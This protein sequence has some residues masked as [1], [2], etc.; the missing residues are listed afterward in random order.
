MLVEHARELAGV[1]DAAHAE[2]GHGGTPVISLLSCSLV[3]TEIDIDIVPGTRLA[4][5]HGS[6]RSTEPTN[7]NYGLAPDFDHL[8]TSGG[9]IVSA[10]DDTGEVRAV[11]RADHPFYLATLYQPQRRSTPESPHPVLTAF[12][13]AALEAHATA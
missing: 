12:I 6:L 2:Y 4:S 10:R 9:L 7:C 8:A 11:E 3:A 13:G 1:A 5:I